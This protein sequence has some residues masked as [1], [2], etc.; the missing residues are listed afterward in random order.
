MILSSLTVADAKLYAKWCATD[1]IGLLVDF[2]LHGDL[3]YKTDTVRTMGFGGEDREMEISSSTIGAFVLKVG[4]AP[5][6]SK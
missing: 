4:C 5:V 6:E 2:E 3:D 1:E